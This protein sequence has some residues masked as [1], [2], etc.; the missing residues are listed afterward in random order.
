MMLPTRPMAHLIIRQPGFALASLEAFFDAMFRFGHS[1]KFPQWRLRHSVG[2]IVVYLHHLLVVS[3]AVADHHQYLLVA[4][5]TPMGSRYHTAFH[6]LNHQRAFGTI[7]PIDPEPGLIRKRLTPRLDAGPGTLGPPPPAALRWGLDLQITHRRVQRH[8]QH[9]PLTQ[10]RQPTTK[11]RGA[12]HLV[13]TGHPALRQTGAVFCQ[14]LQGQLVT[15]AGA[16]VPFRNA[17]FVE[18][19][20][21]LGPCFG[22]VQPCVHQGVALARDVSQVHGHLAVVNF[23]QAA[24]PLTG[25]AHRLA[26]GLGKPRGIEH[27]HSITLSHVRLDLPAP[28]RSQ[29]LIVPLMPA[30]EGWKR[31]TGLATTRGKRCDV[32]ALDIRPQATDR[33][34]GVLTVSLTR[35]DF[36][37]G[38][39]KG[40]QTWDDLFENLR[41]DL[42]FIKQWGFAKGVSRFH[43][44]L[45]RWLIRFT[46]PQ[47]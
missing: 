31:Q 17:S 34:F 22:Q 13:V 23:A 10:G 45:L 14:H 27:Q 19:G 30:N 7:A 21:V 12:P 5:L 35:E 15:R 18:T 43:S 16:S 26:T 42:T 40:R 9:L 32:C 37:K 38:L 46:K 29:G 3:V 1:R 20:L 2:Q 8:R 11:P 39:H 6:R 47:K 33:G 36:D 41:G 4:L 24:T 28:L 25:H 44:K